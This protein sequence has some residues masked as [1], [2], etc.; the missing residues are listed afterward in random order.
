MVRWKTSFPWKT[1]ALILLVPSMLLNV[2]LF[3][4]TSTQPI[5]SVPVVGVIDGDTIVV[6]NK[7]RVR[8]R[9]IDAP[10]LGSCGGE[11]AKREL[12]KLVT[13]KSVRLAEQIPDQQG[14]GMALV[15]EGRT[16]VNEKML[17]S[18]WVTYHHDVSTREEDLKKATALAKE[19]KRGIYGKC[20][21]T[22]NTEKPKCIVKANIDDKGV[23]TYFVPGCAQY[24]F[25]VIEKNRGEAYFCTEKEAVKAGYVKA[26]T[27]AGK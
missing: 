21:S 27:C 8:L 18:G 19:E 15:Y 25:T 1:V 14:R 12:E 3:F 16:L 7:E 4:R 2:Y 24:R 9:Q 22:E 26:G 6:S 23:K 11:E 20:W 5:F 10:E 17:E 13:G